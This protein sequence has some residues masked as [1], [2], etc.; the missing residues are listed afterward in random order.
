MR[1]S[2]TALRLWIAA[3]AFC[4]LHSAFVGCAARRATSDADALTRLRA[5]IVAATRGPGVSRASWGIVVDSLDRRDRLFDL[6]ART[7]FVPASVAKI[8]SLATAAEAVGWDYRFETTLLTTGSVS[9]GALFGD[10]LIVGSGDPSIGGR[11]GGDLSSFVAAV[12]AAGI[13]RIEGRIVGDDDALE[14]PRPQLSWAWDDL[15][16]TTGAL[17]GALNL[18]ENRTFVTVTP[19]TSAGDPVVLSLEPRAT[20]RALVNRTVTGAADTTPLVWPEQRPGEASLTIAGT[21]P[22]GS[23]PMQ[24]GIS[25]GNPTLWFASVLRNCLI[26]DGI[27]VTGDAV[28]VDAVVPAPDRA[29]A[30]RLF[31]YWSPTLAEIARPLFKESINLYGEALMRLNADRGSFPTNDAAL[32]GLGKRLASWGLP[33]GS[34]QLVDGSGLSRRDAISPEAIMTVLQRMSDAP[35]FLDALPIAGLDGSLASRMQATAAAGNVRAKTGTMSNIRSLA[36]YVTT[37]GGER[38]A[39]VIVINN[40]EGNGAEANQAIDAIAVR[41]AEFTRTPR[42]GS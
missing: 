31:T 27:V 16:Y 9:H 38:L 8:I 5:D 13:G 7:L 29:G 32:E 24:L 30:T 28:D 23:Q 15:G 10:L 41:L 1:N 36:G 4:I 40:F 12:K 18:A 37:R 11:G 20:G 39:F 35:Q 6:N 25:T 3:S 2:D 42:S 34:Y 14:E 33:E 17:F 26:E 22:L 21:I 19:G